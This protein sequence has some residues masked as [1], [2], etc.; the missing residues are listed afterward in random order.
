[1]RA[2][3]IWVFGLSAVIVSL[4]YAGTLRATPSSGFSSTTIAL[5]RYADIDVNNHPSRM[6]SSQ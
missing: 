3:V 5:G 4:M 2:K 6:R 1:M